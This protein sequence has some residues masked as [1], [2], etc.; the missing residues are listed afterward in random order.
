MSVI[1]SNAPKFPNVCHVIVSVVEICASRV[2]LALEF[3]ILALEGV[4]IRGDLPCFICFFGW[5]H[6]LRFIKPM[7][8]TFFRMSSDSFCVFYAPSHSLTTAF[9]IINNWRPCVPIIVRVVIKTLFAQHKK[10][11]PLGSRWVLPVRFGCYPLRVLFFP[12]NLI[13]HCQP[14]TIAQPAAIPQ[15]PKVF[16]IAP[17]VHAAIISKK[18]TARFPPLH[19][20]SIQLF[21]V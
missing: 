1:A 3:V 7:T 21:A 8:A 11:A 15:P 2:K 9:K 4:A 13:P 20:K 17:N 19:L 5:H 6:P 12:H 16:R 10:Q 14:F 18:R